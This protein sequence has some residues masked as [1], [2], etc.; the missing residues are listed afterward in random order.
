MRDSHRL[1]A[2]LGRRIRER[3]KLHGLT[4]EGLAERSGLSYQYISS[5]EKGAENPSLETLERI[6]RGLDDTLPNLLSGV[7]QG[8]SEVRS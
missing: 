4:L 3:R 8:M 2:A 6:A 5:L 1:S 7:L